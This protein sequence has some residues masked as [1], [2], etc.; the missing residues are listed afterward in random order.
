MNLRSTVAAAAAFASLQAF[1][2]FSIVARDPATGE[3]GMGV[4]SKAFATASRT[5][6]VK[7]GVVAIAHQ[8]TSNPMYGVLG[9]D[10][11]QVGMTPQQALDII[12]RGDEGR[13]VRQVGMIDMQGRTAAYTGG[14]SPDWKGHHCGTNYCAQGNTLTGPEV[15][16]AIA[17]GFE[18][19]SGPL[20]E[21][22]L[23]ALDAGQAAGG[24]VR[25]MQAGSIVVA[26]AL[27]GTAGFGDRVVDIRVDDSRAPLAELRRL[28]DTLRSN[29]LAAEATNKARAGDMAA[30]ATAAHAAAGK[31]PQNDNA[32]IALT[33]V[34]ARAGRTQEALDAARRAIEINPANRRQLPKNP[35]LESLRADPQFQRI[36]E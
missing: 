27:A 7:G 14:K 13:D 4:Q 25:G 11:I 17:R 33:V 21:R 31:A 18:A 15:V 8:A 30:A 20:A 9:L 28:L 36:T 32:W 35:L 29:Q 1:A 6:T 12:V 3:L 24:D 10:L 23:A 5:I 34:H 26:K 16:E 2:T 22:M 19:S